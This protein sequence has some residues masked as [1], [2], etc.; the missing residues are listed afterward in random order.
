MDQ[1]K[2][3]E[4]IE[5]IGTE[6]LIY[7]CDK[8]LLVFDN[9]LAIENHN[10]HIHDYQVNQKRNLLDCPICGLA[11]LTD[12]QINIHQ[13]IHRSGKNFECQYCLNGFDQMKDRDDHI[14][15]EHP[16]GESNQYV[17]RFLKCTK[18]WKDFPSLLDHFHSEKHFPSYTKQPSKDQ[19][20]ECSLC[21]DSFEDRNSLLIHLLDENHVKSNL[22]NPKIA[23]PKNIH[24]PAK[25]IVSNSL[26]EDTSNKCSICTQVF[27]GSLLDK[28][29]VYH[30]PE[31][32]FE[33]PFCFK[34]FQSLM[35]M[36]KHKNTH[37]R[38]H[39]KFQCFK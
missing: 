35:L 14:E 33:C 24:I 9:S 22:F 30:Q 36:L 39:N 25:S 34:P 27:D 8:C 15:N 11:D 20:C 26:H 13:S 12:N 7:K 38:C 28:R 17:C 32:N 1:E 6:G 4:K 16:E 3:L 23:L 18:R 19:H 31:S 2:F 5:N 10:K 21:G 29:K 37:A